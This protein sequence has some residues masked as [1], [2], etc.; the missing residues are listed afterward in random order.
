MALFSVICLTVILLVIH[1]LLNWGWRD[2]VKERNKVTDMVPIM[3][4]TTVFGLLLT[5]LI[6]QQIIIWGKDLL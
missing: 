1:H 6:I 2:A 5:V 4:T 3:F